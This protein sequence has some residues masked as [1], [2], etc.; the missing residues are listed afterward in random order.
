MV[1][2]DA[3]AHEDLSFIYTDLFVNSHSYKLNSL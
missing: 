1:S 3:A 2:G